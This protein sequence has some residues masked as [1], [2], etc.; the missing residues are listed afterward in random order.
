MLT[1]C[2]NT[3]FLVYNMGMSQRAL[4]IL[5]IKFVIEVYDPPPQMPD[6]ALRFERGSTAFKAVVIAD[7]F[8]SQGCTRGFWGDASIRHARLCQ[9]G[10]LPSRPLSMYWGGSDGLHTHTGPNHEYTHPDTYRYFLTERSDN[11]HIQWEAT[12]ILFD[13][14]IPLWPGVLCRYLY[15]ALHAQC[16]LPDGAVIRTE[17][18]KEF[19]AIDG[20]IYK[21]HRDDQSVLNLAILDTVRVSGADYLLGKLNYCVTIHRNS[22]ITWQE[23]VQLAEYLI[24]RS[25]SKG[26]TVSS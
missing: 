25:R 21:V 4:E 3:R 7:A 26:R 22:Q 8:I 15:C 23:K 6:F 9:N 12:T 19:K 1:A 16:I 13:S 14:S 10:T 18:V 24:S 20:I 11:K 2:H 17:L 5:S